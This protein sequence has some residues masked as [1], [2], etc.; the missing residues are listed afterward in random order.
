MKTVVFVYAAPPI[1]GGGFCSSPSI[2]SFRA[3]EHIYLEALANQ[4]HQNNMDWQAQLDDTYSD[5][6][7]IKDR[8]HAIIC[9]PGLKYQFRTNG[10][11][12][13]RIIHIT[14]MEYW[15]N[16]IARVIKFLKGIDSR[17]EIED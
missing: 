7:L 14:T 4:L 2:F 10:Y 1:L 11:D 17:A 5:I 12:K 15:H 13:K 8:A 9:A 6:S 3:T 16:D